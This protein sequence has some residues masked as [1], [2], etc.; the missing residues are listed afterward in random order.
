MKISDK[1]K[2]LLYFELAKFVRSGF[3]F[4]NA[5]EAILDQ[6]GAPASHRVFCES[7][8]GG[9]RDR[10]TVG[11]AIADVPLNISCLEINMIHAGEDAGLLEQSFEHLEQHFKLAIE[12]RAKILKGLTYP[13]ALLHMGMI[14]GLVAISVISIWNPES[15]K[16]AVWQSLKSGLILIAAF[17]LVAG[18]TVAGF[19]WV[20][21]LAKVSPMADRLLNLIPLIG[22][23]RRNLSLARF[24]EVF[25]MCLRSGQKMDKC[26]TYSGGSSASGLILKASQ[27]CSEAVKQGTTL[28]STLQSFPGTFPGAFTRSVANAEL[29]GVLDEDFQRWTEYYRKTAID[30]VERLAEWAPRLFYWGVLAAAALIIIRMGIAYQ[31]LIQGIL[32]WGDQ[33]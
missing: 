26:L 30:S 29:A 22:K 1:Q 2:Q 19:M 7:V 4:D 6:P 11:Q 12:T 18:A 8:M 25:H 9:L 20:F 31:G 14:F 10:K 28:A 17:Y 21:R 15:E 24:C 13:V 16:G 33:F 23:T 5:C 32:N 3:G 27:T